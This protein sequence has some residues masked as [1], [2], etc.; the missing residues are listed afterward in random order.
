MLHGQW[1]I[2][3]VL[4]KVLFNIGLFS[5]K[6]QSFLKHQRKKI[7]QIT[8]KLSQVLLRTSYTWIIQC[9]ICWHC[10]PSS[11]SYFICHLNC[12]I[13]VN[14]NPITNLLIVI[15][16]LGVYLDNCT[17]NNADRATLGTFQPPGSKYYYYLYYFHYPII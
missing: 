5:Q 10:L 14:S 2:E 1:L 6:V 9:Q 8:S 7:R 12:K 17:V 16:A 4:T 11:V 15:V 13:K 3:L